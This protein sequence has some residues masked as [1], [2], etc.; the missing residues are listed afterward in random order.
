MPHTVSFMDRLHQGH[1]CIIGTSD[2]SDGLKAGGGH[3][4]T[5]SYAQ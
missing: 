2:L 4:Q 1:E 3:L 5:L